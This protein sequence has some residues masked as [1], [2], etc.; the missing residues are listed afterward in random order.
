MVVM[1]PM[2]FDAPGSS[3]QLAPYLFILASFGYVFVIGYCAVASF[4][5]LG[6]DNYNKA[7][8]L[9]KISLS[10]FLVPVLFQIIILIAS[11]RFR[12]EQFPNSK[13]DQRAS[14]LI[15]EKRYAEATAVLSV[16]LERSKENK[17]C[18]AD[19]SHCGAGNAYFDRG[20]AYFKLGKYNEA[21]EDYT[22]AMHFFPDHAPFYM[23]RAMALY[24]KGD[25]KNS[26]EDVKKSET[27]G[28]RKQLKEHIEYWK[29]TDYSERSA[30]FQQK[31]DDYEELVRKLNAKTD[32]AS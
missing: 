4:V 10:V 5:A 26:L 27:L 11:F 17:I 30:E 6:S 25:Y 2:A 28:I 19:R 1:S 12:S 20:Q 15:H 32:N 23:E 29:H 14:Q 24:K 16:M 21:A 22:A 7:F 8:N 3:H 9:S 13:D 31:L 18:K